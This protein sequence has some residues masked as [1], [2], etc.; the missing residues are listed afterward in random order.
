ME[1]VIYDFVFDIDP[2]NA[3]YQITQIYTKLCYK[4][5]LNL[6]ITFIRF[7]TYINIVLGCSTTKY[8][9]NISNYLRFCALCYY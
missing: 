7:N 6:Y 4:T 3:H 5:V 2:A 9:K 8:I 1:Y